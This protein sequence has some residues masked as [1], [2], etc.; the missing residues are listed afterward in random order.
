PRTW[1]VAAALALVASA[2]GSTQ[3][4]TEHKITEDLW[5]DSPVMAQMRW[6]EE[7]FVGIVPSEVLVGTKAGFGERER[8]QLATLCTRIEAQAGVS[9]T[10]SLADLFADGLPALLL[11]VL[12]KSGVLPAG[13]V[14]D[15]GRSAR[16]LVFRGDLGTS[17]WQRYAAAFP[18]LG[19]DLPD[20]RVRLCG[21]QMVGTEQV[22]RMTSDLAWS[23]AGSIV[24]IFVL[25]WLQCRDAGLAGVAMLSCLLPMLAVLALMAATGLTLRPLTVIAFCVAFGLMIDDAIHLIAR[26]QEERRRGLVASDAVRA[27]LATAGRPVV[28]TTLLLLVGFLV[29]LGSGFR[30]TFV[31]GLLVVVSLLGALLAALVPLPA[32]LAVLPARQDPKGPP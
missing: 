23:F 30:G 10:L 32:L 3:V 17:A 2:L 19:A 7:R 4:V 15:D 13:L 5:P 1:L 12:A 25:V 6:Y 9:R 11:P 31:F 28:V 22:L 27:T 8:S 20:L 18:G 16:V 21:L 26:W 14:A 29:I 24:L